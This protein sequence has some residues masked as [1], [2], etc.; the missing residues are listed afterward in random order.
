MTLEFGEIRRKITGSLVDSV[1]TVLGVGNMVR[2]SK[3][4]GQDRDQVVK[5]EEIDTVVFD[6]GQDL[7]EGLVA[8][9]RDSESKLGLL[10][11]ERGGTEAELGEKRSEVLGSAVEWFWVRHG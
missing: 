11:R 9:D 8:E 3:G 6:K 10:V 1:Q 7:V 5:V 2:V 4:S